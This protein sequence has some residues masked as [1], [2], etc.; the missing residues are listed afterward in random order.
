MEFLASLVLTIHLLW[1]LWV[2]FG[3]FWTRGRP[4]LTALH[5]L[6]LVWGIVV[7]LSP[8]PCPLTITEQFFERKVG[9]EAYA[10]TFLAHLLDRLV[11]P[12][13]PE[14]LLVRVGVAVCTIN[15]ALYIRR[16]LE[17]RSLTG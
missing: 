2:V 11:Y 3:E 9:T 15:I 12:S 17:W 13:L 16:F 1:I 7:E 10:G 8:L 6:S 5:I 4:L 14:A